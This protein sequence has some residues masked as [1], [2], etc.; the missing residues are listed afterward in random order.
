M[1]N[2]IATITMSLV[3]LEVVIVA[4]VV[5]YLQK[6]R[7]YAREPLHPVDHERLCKGPHAWK[8]IKL[9]HPDEMELMQMDPKTYHETLEASNYCEACGYVSGMEKMLKPEHLAYANQRNAER[10]E[11]LAQEQDFEVLKDEYLAKFLKDK[12]FTEKDKTLIREGFMLYDKFG[13][14]VSDLL[15]QQRLI[16]LA[17]KWEEEM[18]ELENESN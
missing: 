3:C 12:S 5:T 13:L 16:R 7:T 11:A 2:L 6:V 18:E 17:K 4:A 8:K 9:V 14:E 15:A 1:F 10:D